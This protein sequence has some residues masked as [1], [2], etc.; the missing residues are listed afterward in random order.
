MRDPR[1][2]EKSVVLMRHRVPAHLAR[3]F[4]QICLGAAAEVVEPAGITPAEY[5]LLAAVD[6]CPGLDQRQLAASLG[7]DAVSAGQ[8]IDRLEAGGWITR[9]MDPRDRRVRLIDPTPAGTALR[10]S[11]RPA[12]L[13]VQRRIMAVLSQEEQTLFLDLLTRL[14]EGNQSYAR[15]G[16]G[17]RR[18]RPKAEGPDAADAQVLV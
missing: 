2:Q 4:H 17:R 11:L 10:A 1:G 18:P 12:A 3:R 9:Q 16:N 6:D 14:V 8:T 7:I 5:G 13:A 15:P